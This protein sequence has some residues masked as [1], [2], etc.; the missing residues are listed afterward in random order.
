MEHLVMETDR[1]FK[2]LGGF[3]S[4]VL[5]CGLL[6]M[7]LGD[8]FEPWALVGSAF[9][10]GMSIAV[11]LAGHSQWKEGNTM[12][13]DTKSIFLSQ[14]IVDRRLQKLALEFRAAS[15]EQIFGQ[16]LEEREESNKTRS[17]NLE[18]AKGAFWE[19]WTM[20]SRLGFKVEKKW[21][22]YLKEPLHQAA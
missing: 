22:N 9:F 3:L 12:V 1:E 18:R 11:Y 19:A 8:I 4:S 13:E 15:D 7:W 17:L 20:A 2:I 10:I 21:T 5:I 16:T 6:I 14:G